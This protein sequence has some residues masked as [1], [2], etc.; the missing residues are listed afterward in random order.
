MIPKTKNKSVLLIADDPG[1]A[2]SSPTLGYG[3]LLRVLSL[4]PNFEAT[5]ITWRS[6][7]SLFPIIED[8]SALNALEDLDT[9]S[10]NLSNFDFVIN[11][12]ST[13]LKTSPDIFNLFDFIDTTGNMKKQLDRLPNVLGAELSFF[14]KPS[15]PLAPTPSD[16]QFDFGLNTFVPEF[17][18]IKELP[19]EHW[20]SIADIIGDKR[21]VSWQPETSSLR[22]YVD[23]IK[24]CRVII[25]VVG[26]GC[27][28]AE[29]YGIPLVVLSGPTDY[30][31]AHESSRN[32][33]LFPPTPCEHRPCFLPTGV[34]NCG[35]M[36]EFAPETVTLRAQKLL[37]MLT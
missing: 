5:Q 30:P 8:C 9:L 37:E 20:R 11:L 19:M 2:G 26:L 14:P 1:S 15:M 29:L 32:E 33:V 10:L 22:V 27:H 21:K 25:S 3:D 36:G 12:S 17:W 31:E 35:C 34:D 24:S 13:V 23:W 6:P 16:H 7:S 4:A 18:S 28:I